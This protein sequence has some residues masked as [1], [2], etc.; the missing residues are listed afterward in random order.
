[1]LLIVTGDSNT[2]DDTAER[3]ERVTAPPPTARSP[4]DKVMGTETFVTL[5]T[6]L[7]AEDW[8]LQPWSGNKLRTTAGMTRL[9]KTKRPGCTPVRTASIELKMRD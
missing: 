3:S 7:S 9:C 8:A 4:L 2:E 1:L 6:L 5:T